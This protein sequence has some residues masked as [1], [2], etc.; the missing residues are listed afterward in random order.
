MDW[1][2][3]GIDQ[4]RWCVVHNSSSFII[5]RGDRYDMPAPLIR[6]LSPLNINSLGT[7]KVFMFTGKSLIICFAFF[8]TT[9][10]YATGIDFNVDIGFDIF[11]GKR[12][13]LQN[14][15]ASCFRAFRGIES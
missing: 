7:A 11:N 4:K 10:K 14:G 13:I 6:L 2:S 9:Q 3:F 1:A 15:N 12:I 8:C 5:V